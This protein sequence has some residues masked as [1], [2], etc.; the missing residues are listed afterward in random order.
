MV[1]HIL[2]SC[3]PFSRSIFPSIRVL[4]RSEFFTTGGQSIKQ[5]SL[6]EI[7]LVSRLAHRENIT[8]FP[9]SHFRFFKNNNNNKKTISVMGDISTARPCI[10]ELNSTQTLISPTRLTWKCLYRFPAAS[11]SLLL[12]K[13]TCL[14]FPRQVHTK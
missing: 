9:P 7:H 3:R 1:I 4:S 13:P 6:L 14:V 2:P 10:P 5:I 11:L 8:D 12:P